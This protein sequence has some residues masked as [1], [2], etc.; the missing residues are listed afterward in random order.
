M[1]LQS[2]TLH[3]HGLSD[4]DYDMIFTK[5]K[6]IVFAFHGYANLIH[7]LTYRRHNS[8]LH[9]RG[10]NEEGSITTPFD[11]RVLNEVDRYHLVML[12]LKHLTDFEDKSSYL[13]EYC[14]NMLVKHT[15]YIKE[16]GVDMPEVSQWTW[17]SFVKNH[18]SV[19]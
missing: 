11:M 13:L 7:E 3:P 19:S 9:V 18:K 15:E 6:P 4:H 16:H 2:D 17:E 14:K 8:H 1:K 12:A 5:N 10:Y